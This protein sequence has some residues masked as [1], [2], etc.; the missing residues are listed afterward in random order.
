[1]KQI[2]IKTDTSYTTPRTS[3][4]FLL[5]RKNEKN[6]TFHNKL[7]QF[8]CLVLI[9]KNK[10][11]KITTKHNNYDLSRI[12]EKSTTVKNTTKHNN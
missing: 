12:D 8:L 5:F 4:A 1:M 10:I 11:M 3:G 6:T 9:E 2:A 7:Q